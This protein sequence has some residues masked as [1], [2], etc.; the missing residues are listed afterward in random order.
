MF[1]CANY[2]RGCRGR[3]N[4]QGGKCSDCVQLKLRRPLS[5]SPFAQPRD[6]RRALPSEILNDSPFKE[7]ERSL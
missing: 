2:P 6:Y 3:V 5:A 4:I 7:I 1:S